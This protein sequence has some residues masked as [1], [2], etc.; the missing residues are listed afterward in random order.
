MAKHKNRLLDPERLT[1]PTGPHAMIGMAIRS[2]RIAKKMTAQLLMDFLGDET[3]TRALI[4]SYENGRYLPSLDRLTRILHSLDAEVTDEI[5]QHYVNCLE[6]TPGYG[7]VNPGGRTRI[8][9]A[10]EIISAWQTAS[11]V[12]EAA[13][14]LG[15]DKRDLVKKVG[16]LRVRGVPLKKFMLS[17]VDYDKL[18]EFASQ[19][20]SRIG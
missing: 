10:K 11:S 19:F 17:K 15:I 20:T 2:A 5:R 14:L 12:Q 7:Q 1:V 6:I 4:S 3:L 8:G 9:D 13:D 18:K 16:N